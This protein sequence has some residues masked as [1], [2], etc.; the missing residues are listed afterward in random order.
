M[1]LVTGAGGFIGSQVCQ[2]LSAHGQDIVA[3]DR[4][5]TTP[6]PAHMVQGDLISHNILLRLFQEYSFDA[7]IHLASLLNTASRQN[8]DEAMRVNIG[9]SLS[10]LQLAMQ[11]KIAKFIFGSSISV[12]G[13]KPYADYGEVSESEPASPNTVY[14]VSKRY[15]EIVGEHFRQQEHLQFVALRLSMV[16][17]TGANSTT[18]PWRSE[19]FE[20]MQ[21]SE[22]TSI[23]LPC[24][25]H[26]C[27]PLI[28]VADVAEITRRLSEVERTMYP[29]YNAPSDNWQCGD[30]ADYIRSLNPNV[31]LTFNPSQSRGNPE[32]ITGRRFLEEFDF[33]PISV[34]ERLR[35]VVEN[36]DG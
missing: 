19:I 12:Y 7:I 21:E 22:R 33:T 15:V 28:H 6:L 20:K 23:R 31:E 24:A 11:F 27:L 13:S 9:G 17:G 2:L 16:I 1:I 5:F 14:G 10:L 8:P 34:K 30:L 18:S 29:I 26:E 3:V 35:W 4:N 32:A 25:S 36:R